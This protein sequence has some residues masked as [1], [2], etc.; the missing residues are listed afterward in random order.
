V[1]F[2]EHQLQDLTQQAVNA[3]RAAGSV[4]DT[5]RQTQLDVQYKDVG[6]SLASQ[7][8][9]QVDRE[10]Q[11]VILQLLQS[12]CEQY[13]L[14][15]LTEESP[16]D[17]QRHKKKAFWCIDPLDGTLAFINNQPGFSVSIALVSQEGE[18]LIGVVYDPLQK[19]LFHAAY[20]QGALKMEMP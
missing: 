19:V 20:Y 9:T 10:A 7:V 18:S 11:T 1:L 16:D 14:A 6:N 12:S 13:D 5:Y 15:L 17:G 8:V 4:I 2:N 3:A